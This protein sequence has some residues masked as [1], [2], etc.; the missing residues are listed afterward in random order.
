[1]GNN[2]CCINRK[3]EG[4]ENYVYF[5]TKS[6]TYLNKEK[7]DSII[8]RN[9]NASLAFLYT[10]S[11]IATFIIICTG[12]P[13]SLAISAILGSGFAVYYIYNTRNDVKNIFF[14]NKILDKRDL[15]KI[16]V[17]ENVSIIKKK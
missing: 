13:A 9:S 14:I 15:E 16:S 7:K 5:D 10:G 12:G 17:L 8:S 2:I 4:E 11:S 3:I 6:D 1:M